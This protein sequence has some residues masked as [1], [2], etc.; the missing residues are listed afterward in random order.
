[1]SKIII[2]AALGFLVLLTMAAIIT[3]LLEDYHSHYIDEEE[4]PNGTDDR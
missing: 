1:V 4:D 2:I 3:A